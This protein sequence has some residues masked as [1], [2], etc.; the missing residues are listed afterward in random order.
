MH[1]A[2]V[3]YTV[4]VTTDTDWYSPAAVNHSILIQLY[5]AFT[6]ALLTQTDFRRVSLLRPSVTLRAFVCFRH[7]SSNHKWER[8]WWF[9]MQF[10]SYFS[11]EFHLLIKSHA[12]QLCCILA[13]A[14]FHCISWNLE[15]WGESWCFGST[16]ATTSEN[17]LFSYVFFDILCFSFMFFCFFNSHFVFISFILRCARPPSG[18]FMKLPGRFV[19]HGCGSCG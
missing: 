4:H 16:S 9:L 19:E 14:H 2:G 11:S 17:G 5:W 7:T 6:V 12:C 3:L 13:D 8:A 1:L 10:S 15:G 18:P